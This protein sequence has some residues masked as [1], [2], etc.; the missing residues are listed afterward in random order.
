MAIISDNPIAEPTE[1]RPPTQSQNPNM[2]AVSMPN[3]ATFSAFVDTAT[4]WSATA[5]S[6]SASTSQ[7][8]AVR[9]FVSVSIVPNVFEATMN[10]VDAGSESASTAAMSAP[11]TLET[12]DERSRGC[13]NACERP[14][15]HR[16]AEVGA[17]DADVDDVGD[18]LVGADPI[19]ERRHLVEHGVHVGHDV[20]TVDD[21]RHVGR[22]PQRDV[23]HGPILGDVDVLT[24]EHRVASGLDAALARP[25]RAVR[26]RIGVVDRLLR[27]V[28]PEI[29]DLDD[30]PV[31]P[32]GVVGEQRR[33]VGS[34]RQPPQRGEGIGRRRSSPPNLQ[35]DHSRGRRAVA[36][37]RRT[38]SCRCA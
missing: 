35:R 4:K 37:D 20:G 16:R 22:R 23:H 13:A 7:A 6:P 21:H 15:R 19:G 2:F 14:R 29:A 33:E 28:D 32:A 26:A 18:P 5:S 9:A 36:A 38:R 11:S 34:M 27:V 17:A 1:Y 12:N 10:S 24:G 31:G 25:A 3:A 30:V 8:R